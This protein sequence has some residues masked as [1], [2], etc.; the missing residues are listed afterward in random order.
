[1]SF[2]SAGRQVKQ[3]F[4]LAFQGYV[5]V[6]PEAREMSCDLRYMKERSYQSLF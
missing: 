1:M 2:V 5:S 4:L 3:C 6:D